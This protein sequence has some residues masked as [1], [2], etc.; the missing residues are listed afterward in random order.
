VWLLIHAHDS[1]RSILPC[2]HSSAGPLKDSRLAMQGCCERYHDGALE[3]TAE[4]V[5]RARFSAYI[6]G[7]VREAATLSIG[8]TR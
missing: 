4:A 6:K 2:G 7:E 1:V 3:P 8:S 5:M